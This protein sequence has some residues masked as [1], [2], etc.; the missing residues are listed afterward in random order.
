MKR[1]YFFIGSFMVF[2]AIIGYLF[3]AQLITTLPRHA[4]WLF[5]ISEK[6]DMEAAQRSLLFLLGTHIFLTR[7]VV[8]GLSI[9][10]FFI[11]LCQL[12]PHIKISMDKDVKR[13]KLY[14]IVFV[15]LAIFI[16]ALSTFTM[17]PDLVS[18]IMNLEMTYKYGLFR[19]MA[20][21]GI[22]WIVVGEKGW[23]GNLKSWNFDD[24]ANIKGLLS[25]FLIGAAA[26]GV[27]YCMF[28]LGHWSFTNYN[29]LVNEVWNKT[30]F[31][32]VSFYWAKLESL[33]LMLILIF[34]L[35]ITAAF[36][37]LLAPVNI[38]KKERFKRSYAPF[39]LLIAYII[40]VS[41][42]YLTA[43]ERYDLGKRNL[44][45]ATGIAERGRES[46]MVIFFYPEKAYVQEWPMQAQ[47]MSYPAVE[48]TIELSYE[49]LK[50]VEKYL[51][52]HKEGSVFYCIALGALSHG[53]FQL[54]D[55][56][57][58]LEQIFFNSRYRGFYRPQLL[59]KLQ[60]LPIIKENERYLR[61]VA[62]ETKW[63]AGKIGAENLAKSFM[64]FGYP[65]EAKEWVR[66]ARDRGSK[67]TESLITNES[68]FTQGTIRGRLKHNSKPMK[69]TKVAL[70]SYVPGMDVSKPLS[71]VWTLL[72]V[73]K[74]DN[75]GRFNFMN[76]AKG[77]YILAVMTE[78]EAVPYNLPVDK[79][80]VTNT[81]KLIKLASNT[82]VKD[83]GSINIS[84]K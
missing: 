41:G 68:V 3:Y 83:L 49:N 34:T 63:Y 30:S 48:N 23:A 76:L 1:N 14:C 29:T 44:A 32:N 84:T 4:E 42:V 78:A 67:I 51:E 38:T 54:W 47:G 21:T 50:I 43:R 81:P 61:D 9:I 15:S 73:Q 77:Q 72:D 46:K 19:V 40:L 10:I 28:M 18:I 8:I 25:T 36:I 37:A 55:V 35:G 80:K 75:Q 79:F 13:A 52:R 26:G 39:L 17:A 24:L 45:T 65:D 57:R 74:T 60:T 2:G 69:Q 56:R 12:N 20:G 33:G 22:I 64:H 5:T 53:Y 71:L 59:Y 27:A 6:A 66:K 62:D 16:F 82:P 11:M 58:G 7:A 70:F 31:D